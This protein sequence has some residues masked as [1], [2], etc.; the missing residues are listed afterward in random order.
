MLNHPSVTSQYIPPEEV[1]HSIIKHAIRN[2]PK[3]STLHKHLDGGG[4]IDQLNGLKIPK[5]NTAGNERLSLSF[6]G[7]TY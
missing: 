2:I 7:L 1:Q 3:A 5:Y 4:L 6:G